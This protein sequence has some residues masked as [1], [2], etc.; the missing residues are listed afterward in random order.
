MIRINFMHIADE[1]Q[2]IQARALLDKLYMEGSD[3]E[4]ADGQTVA[5]SRGRQS[6]S[7]GSVEETAK[8]VE[9][10]RK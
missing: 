7:G 9:P 1:R 5:A 2:R 6:F 10:S 4:E 8:A 3:E